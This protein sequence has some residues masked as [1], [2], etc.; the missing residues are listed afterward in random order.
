MSP[1]YGTRRPFRSQCIR[2]ARRPRRAVR[3]FS[4]IGLLVIS[5]AVA[6]SLAGS[7]AAVQSLDNWFV[8]AGTSLSRTTGPNGTTGYEVTNTSGGALTAVLND[9]V[10][11][12]PDTVQG[13][14]YVVTASVRTSNAVGTTVGLR[15]MEYSGSTYHGQAQSTVWLR[16]TAWHQLTTRYVAATNH[17]QIDV[18]ALAWALPAGGSF[19]IG[20]ISFSTV[21][22]SGPPGYHLVWR[23]EFN[24]TSLNT[25]NW[26]ALNYSTYGDG[27]GELACLMDRPANLSESGGALHLI[28]RHESPPL[29]CGYDPRFPNGRNYSSAMITTQGKESF[30]YGY[31]EIRAKLPTQANTSQGMWPAFWLRPVSGGIGELDALEAIGSGPSNNTEVNKVH[32]TIWYDYSGTYPDQTYT[33]AF[34]SGAPSDGYHTYAVKWAPGLMQWIVDGRVTYTRTSA[35]TSW[36]DSAFG[37]PFYIRLNLA[38]GGSWPGSPTS[39]TAF[40]ESYDIDYIRVYQQ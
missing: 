1:H 33:Y 26:N 32:Q 10:N 40:P 25:S 5:T 23:D 3:I 13:T 34:P 16:D 24:G 15:E 28:A 20:A 22:P 4:I 8:N 6:T 9:K 7:A 35:T 11:S 2:R 14:T 12:F 39:S 19:D 27:N 29:K 36:L 18:N 31:L 30:K 21:A 37:Q 17:A 38:V